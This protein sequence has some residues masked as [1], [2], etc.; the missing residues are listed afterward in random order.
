[1]KIKEAINQVI[2]EERVV[3]EAN[4]VTF[5]TFMGIP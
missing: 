1:M 2:L 4:N 3:A 5:D